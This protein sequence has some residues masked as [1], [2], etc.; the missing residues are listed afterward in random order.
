MS[1]RLEES[2]AYCAQAK[3]SLLEA[4]KAL[5]YTNALCF[6]LLLIR[7]VIWSFKGCEY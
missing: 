7:Y 3:S 2:F 5:F 4:R 6:S 1:D